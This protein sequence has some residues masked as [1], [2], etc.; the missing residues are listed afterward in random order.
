MN[1]SKFTSFLAHGIFPHSRLWSAILNGYLEASLYWTP[2]THRNLSR[3][4]LDSPFVWSLLPCSF[5]QQHTVL[6]PCGVLFTML[7]L[8]SI[9]IYGFYSS[10]PLLETLTPLALAIQTGSIKRFIYAALN[11][12]LP[13]RFW[14]CIDIRSWLWMLHG[15]IHCAALYIR[16]TRSFIQ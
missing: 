4:F 16:E 13:W 5:T 6:N 11:S 3:T 2:N 8:S 15:F 7:F 1:N 12:I 10:R 14:Q 9:M